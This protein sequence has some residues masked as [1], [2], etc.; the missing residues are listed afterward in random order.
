LIFLA[1]M[2]NMNIN[3]GNMVNRPMMGNNQMGNNMNQMRQTQHQVQL[4]I[5]CGL[6]YESGT[7][8]I[9]NNSEH[10]KIQFWPY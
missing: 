1:N 5:F 10:K 9:K 7:I 6:G 4:L 3:M 2:N 8:L